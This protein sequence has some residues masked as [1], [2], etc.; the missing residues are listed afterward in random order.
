MPT[1]PLPTA[2]L[3]T[4]PLPVGAPPGPPP[5]AGGQT[6]APTPGA[7]FTPQPPATRSRVPAIVGAVLAVAIG[8]AAVLWFTRGSDDEQSDDTEQ[9]TATEGT[10]ATDTTATPDTAA[11]TTVATTVPLTLPGT[12]APATTVTTP[13]VTAL[14]TDTSLAPIPNVI[15]PGASLYTDPA[16]WSISV[17][18][19]WTFQ[20]QA[21][22]TGWF[23]GTGS[24]GFN[25]NVNVVTEDLPSPMTLDD[26]VVAALDVIKG[27][28]ADANV[29]D[30]R[31]VIGDDGVVVTV[32]AWTG[33]LPDLPKL[34]FIQAMV[35]SPT[36]AYVA[37]FTSEPGRAA[38]LAPVIGPYLA[39]I[40][41]T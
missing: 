32:V 20:Q 14:P 33:T 28:A 13:P 9:T 7:P 40:R 15:P 19:A 35:V 37:T 38:D 39:S 27:Q 8:A 12:V 18:P 23:T 11:A 17:D 24:D 26:Y 36:R 2:P 30:Q 6:I 22:F 3:P 1:A 10:E 16:G 4:A 34:A 29:I 5:G 41:G 25:D 31:Q 21:G